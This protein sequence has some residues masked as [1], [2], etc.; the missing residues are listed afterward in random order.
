MEVATVAIIIPGIMA[1]MVDIMA[2]ITLTMGAH[3]GMGTTMDIMTTIIT[4][5]TITDIWTTGTIMDT[6]VHPMQI[7][8]VQRVPPMLIPNT[9]VAQELNNLLLELPVH[10]LQVI[11]S[12]L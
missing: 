2:D 1:D 4:M 3:T 6:P 11:P 5:T 8:V 12:Q 9:G 10:P 7:T